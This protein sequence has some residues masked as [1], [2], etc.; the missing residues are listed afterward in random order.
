MFKK[1]FPHDNSIE[2]LEDFN[3]LKKEVKQWSK[4]YKDLHTDVVRLSEKVDGWAHQIHLREPSTMLKRID[5]LDRE[6][7]EVR[8]YASDN[9]KFQSKK[10]N[11]LLKRIKPAKGKKPLVKKKKPIK[12]G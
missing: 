5:M 10:I 6:V 3:D 2:K 1:I 8:D 9:F 7:D 12:K 4:A 11:T